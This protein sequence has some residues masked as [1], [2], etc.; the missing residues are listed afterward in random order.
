MRIWITLTISRLGAP[1]VNLLLNLSLAWPTSDQARWFI[2]D[3]RTHSEVP[4][5]WLFAE[6]LLAW[7]AENLLWMCLRMFQDYRGRLASEI[8]GTCRSLRDINCW[9]EETIIDRVLTH[10]LCR[11]AS[12]SNLMILDPCIFGERVWWNVIDRSPLMIL[13]PWPSSIRLTV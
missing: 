13:T 7:G 12:K 3:F 5:S 9:Y 11:S 2:N 8:R 10:A 1:A 4:L 6:I